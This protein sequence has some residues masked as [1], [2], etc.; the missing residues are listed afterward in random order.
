MLDMPP[1]CANSLLIHH[2]WNKERLFDRYYA[3][4]AGERA[5]AGIVHL[6]TSQRPAS[7]F[8][9]EIC[10][11]D[12]AARDGFALGCGHV[13]CRTCWADFLRAAV[14]D[15]GANCISS[16]CP[17]GC[18]EAVTWS[19]VSAFAAPDVAAKWAQFELKHFVSV[20]KNMAWCPAPGCSRAFV[21]RTAVKSAV[22]TCGTK[23]CFKC[24]KESHAPVSCEALEAWLEKCSNES[25]TAN[26]LLANT[27]KCPKCA[28]RI[29][30]NQGCNHMKCTNKGCRYE[31][32]WTC[33]GDWQEHGQTTGGY[34]KCNKF[35]SSGGGGAGAKG[36]TDQARLELERYLFYYIR[37]SGHDQSGRFA[38]KNREATQKR[39]ADLAMLSGGAAGGGGW[40]E[41]AF[42][43][44]AT[45]ALLECRRVLKYTYVYGFYLTREGPEKT[46]FEHLQEQLERSTEHLAEL[47]EAPLDKMDRGEVVNF[48]R[49]TTQFLRHL[50]D[51]LEEGLTS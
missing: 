18:G 34:Y 48:T 23:F 51:G 42:L 13:F 4:P 28:A 15:N 47:T 44:A 3:D 14:T 21:A 1:E 16:R 2:S 6:G 10:L 49:V 37:Y 12:R 40:A 45:E 26:W 8:M 22:C 33:L 39:M 25:E 43:E 5:A 30:K 38:A 9:C 7:G 41:V 27:K 35:K 29:E 24:S 32:C 11:E 19:V 31:F 20:S 50:L 17:A 46:L 36:A